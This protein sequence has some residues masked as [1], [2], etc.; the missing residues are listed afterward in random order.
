MKKTRVILITLVLL[1]IATVVI[2]SAYFVKASVNKIIVP[3][4][5]KTEPADAMESHFVNKTPFNLLLI[6]Y[7]GGTHDGANLTDS[8]IVAHLDPKNKMTTLISIPR[9]IWT[10]IPSDTSNGLK[11]KINYA[12][13]VGLDDADFPNKPAEF[14]GESG[15]GN[16][17]KSV[18]GNVVGLPLDNYVGMD[19][20]GFRQTIDSLDGVDINVNPGFDDYQYPIEGK[21]DD[22][23]GHTQDEIASLSAQLA[24]PSANLSELDAFPCRYEHLHFDPGMQHMDGTT[25]L[26]YVRS[27]HSLQDGTDFGRAKRQRNLIEAVK[28]KVF[29]VGLISHIIPFMASLKDDVTTDLT[30]TDIQDLIKHAQEINS[31]SVHTLALT[32]QNFLVDA[33]TSDGQD[34][35]EPSAGDDNWDEVHA[36]IKKEIDPNYVITNPSIQVENGTTVVGLA[37][38]AATKLQKAGLSILPSQNAGSH[39]HKTTTIQVYGNISPAVLR[40]LEQTLGVKA[41]QHS[42]GD[43]QGQYDILV[44]IGE[45]FKS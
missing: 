36:W 8:I 32:D 29:S 18:V 35:L 43:S 9:D 38:T 42:S 2:Y 21:E 39:D 40:K 44:T 31:Y 4:K 24:S 45:D 26:K 13:Q 33:V 16:M 10:K 27:R 41:I 11:A 3:N 37:D 7:G 25:A 14:K 17:V 15:G 12:Y 22:A 20:S 23:C 30:L 34:V 5:F 28:Q 6:G 1:I 19:F